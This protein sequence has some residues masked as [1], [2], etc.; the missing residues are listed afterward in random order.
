MFS[1]KQLLLA[2]M[3]AQRARILRECLSVD[4]PTFVN[5][6]IYGDWTPANLL[7]H[8]GEYDEFYAGMVRDALAGR[9]TEQGV[10][11]SAIRD[12]LL[13]ERV[14]TWSLEQSVEF[15]MESRAHFVE[16]FALVE[17]DSLKKGYRFN[18]K[19]GGK[20]GRSVGRIGTWAKWRATHDAGHWIDLKD[21][22]QKLTIDS[23]SGG[24]RIVLKAALEAARS[25]FM[26]TATLVT[27]AERD[28]RTVCGDWT[29][30]DVVGHL[31]DWDQHSLRGIHLIIGEPVEPLDWDEDDEVQNARMVEARKKQSW[32]Q[33]WKDFVDV[34]AELMS[35]LDYLNEEML[36]EPYGG[37]DI[38]QRSAYHV[39]WTALEHDLD[40]AASTRRQLAVRLPKTLMTFKPQSYT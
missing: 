6:R 10:D 30:K 26:T 12:H 3:A 32:D 28:T 27:E 1:E 22:R 31:A 14:G 15:M 25:D 23:F 24:D 8:L 33:V 20:T 37:G 19:F 9:I 35:Q 16:A 34:R 13:R 40:H 21:W 2:H 36:S 39:F 5:T 17:G 4:G 29:L 11:Y 18:W 38:S 7:A